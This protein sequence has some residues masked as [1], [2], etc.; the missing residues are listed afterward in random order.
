MLFMDKRILI[1]KARSRFG[2][3][4]IPIGGTEL[5]FGV[6]YG[7][8]EILTPDFLNTIEKAEII[9]FDFSL[10]ENVVDHQYYPQMAREIRQLSETIRK[11]YTNK[12]RNFIVT[13]G[14]D[15]SIASSSLLSVL[16]MN[17]DKKVGVIMFDSHGD[18]H[19]KKT[20]P[21]GNYHGMWL[22]P[23]WDVYDDTQI[24]NTIDISLNTDQLLFIG[25]LLLEEEEIDFLSKNKVPVF[26]SKKFEPELK[27][28]SYT[29]ILNFCNQHDLI[30]ISFD[31]D[32]FKTAL[33]SATGTPNHDGFNKEMIFDIIETL[34]QSGKIISIDLVEV[35]PRKSGAV[36]TVALAQ[37]VL[38]AFL[39]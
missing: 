12:D 1:V 11:E 29:H 15:H 39:K 31:I 7:P 37:D 32:V 33:V 30:H 8:D 18:L 23:F 27:N 34:K 21:T 19:L 35:N 14:G 36:E 6:E 13:V 2:M 5:N 26:S 16:K 3:K 17:I 20:S 25:N 10:P 38:Q 24:K 4:Y 9:D 22:R 28:D